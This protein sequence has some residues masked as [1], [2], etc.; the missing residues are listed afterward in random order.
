MVISRSTSGAFCFYVG[1]GRN[2]NGLASGHS[3]TVWG[4]QLRLCLAV[5]SRTLWN[6]AL[7]RKAQGHLP[8]ALVLE[9]EALRV[10]DTT[11]DE[12][13]KKKT[14]EFIAKWEAELK[15]SPES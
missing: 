10:L 11:Q 9:R 15:S 4:R 6:L 7:L 2:T 5:L 3:A 12:A 8:A 13:A 1:G 14:R